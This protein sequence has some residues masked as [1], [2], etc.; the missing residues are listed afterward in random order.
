MSPTMA[1]LAVMPL[2][3]AQTRPAGSWGWELH[4]GFSLLRIGV[5]SV[6][7]LPV[8]T[9]G[10][11]AEV[12]L[13][14]HADLGVRYTTWLGFDHRLGPELQVGTS[15]GPDWG[16]GA[17]VH[18]A[19]R[20]AG[21]ASETVELGGDV[22]V[23]ASAVVSARLGRHWLTV[24]GGATVQLVLFERLEGVGFVDARPWLATVDVALELAWGSKHTRA[25]ATR[26]ELAIPTAPNDP[27]SVG[28]VR[29]RL[30]LSGHFGPSGDPPAEE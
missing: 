7:V 14:D 25:L 28:G 3:L 1:A 11:A 13:G 19:L 22:S 16:L 12:A 4:A 23:P 30:V 27:L 21:T 8:L 5:P 29:P 10:A 2:Q 17:R 24:E 15:L 9:G 6:P 18:P 26:L 20:I